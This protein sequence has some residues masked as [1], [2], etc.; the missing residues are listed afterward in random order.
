MRGWALCVLAL[1]LAAATW[2]PGPTKVAFAAVGVVFVAIFPVIGTSAS[3]LRAGA[4]FA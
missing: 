4:R 2:V 1:L 3:L